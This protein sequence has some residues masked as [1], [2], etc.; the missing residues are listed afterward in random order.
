MKLKKIM[1]L[2]L[3]FLFACQLFRNDV[4]ADANTKLSKSLQ[5]Y[6][7]KWNYPDIAFYYENLENG[8][9]YYYR[10]N[11]GYYP[12]CTIKVKG[13]MNLYDKI[14]NGKY[15]ENT[16]MT[17]MPADY[18]GGSGIIIKKG[19]NK[20]YTLSQLAEYAVRYSDNAAYIMTQKYMGRRLSYVTGSDERSV[21]PLEA[22]DFLKRLYSFIQKKDKYSKDLSRYFSTTIYNDGIPKGIDK[23]YRVLHKAGDLPKSGLNHDIALVMNESPY[24]LNIYTGSM[25][26]YSKSDS[27][28]AG[29]ARII[30]NENRSI[31]TKE[32]KKLIAK[33]KKLDII[34]GKSDVDIKSKKITE[35]EF[36]TALTKYISKEY[37]YNVKKN[38]YIDLAKKLGM[39]DRSYSE[40][41]ILTKEKAAY[42]I[43]K[44][45]IGLYKEI[46]EEYKDE[47]TRL[48]KNYKKFDT[49]E[50][51]AD[52]T[53]FSKGYYKIA[54]KLLANNII[55]EP[56]DN[57][58][59]PKMKMNIV[60]S[61]KM[62]DTMINAFNNNF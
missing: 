59:K 16:K 7:K 38:N 45:Y 62:I 29:L 47:S 5:Q 24:I 4:W 23:D 53:E 46:F 61:F 32:D 3:V 21:N 39:L 33:G 15:N 58:F 8:T 51:I 48:D 6:M 37:G 30:E 28:M 56:S 55:P 10:K 11:K 25:G 20:Q 19:Y 40:K 60:D 9:T 57:Y 2:S 41:A 27:F 36:V 52:Q 26:G 49:K 31:V 43:E 42:Y 44:A 50:K 1:A 34:K 14:R 35:K 22:K 13:I 54:I 17:Y 18:H 12:C